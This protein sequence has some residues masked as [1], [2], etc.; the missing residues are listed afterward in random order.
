MMK[1]ECLFKETCKHFATSNCNVDCYPYKTL[2]AS[3][4]RKSEFWIV[5]DIMARMIVKV[6]EP[7][8]DLMVF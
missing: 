4:K 1:M 5:P 8:R 6:E 3:E 2:Y 7:G